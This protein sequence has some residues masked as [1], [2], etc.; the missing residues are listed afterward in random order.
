MSNNNFDVIVVGLGAMGSAAV[1]QL[2]KKH[3][4]VLGIDQ[5]APPHANG[6]SHGET[7]VTRQAIC[8]GDEFVPL[9]LR[10]HEI[11]RDL[12][13]QTGVDLM[14]LCGGLMMTDEINVTNHTSLY[15]EKTIAS[16]KKF[17]IRHELLRA[18][19][20]RKKFPQFRLKGSEIGY[21]EFNTGFLR[22]ERCISV[23]LALA[24]KLGASL[25]INEKVVDIEPVSTD[26]VIVKTTNGSYVGGKVILAVGPWI[27]SLLDK[28]YRHLFKIYRQVLYWFEYLESVL[29]S[30]QR[31]PI[32]M[33]ETNSQKGEA[34]YGFPAVNG[35]GGGIKI[36]FEQFDVETDVDT[37]PR[38]ITAGEKSQMYQQYVFPNFHGITQNVMKTVTCMYTATPDLKFIIDNHPKFPQLLLASPCSGHGF[39]HSAA[40]GEVLAQLAVDGKNTIDIS[41]FT[42]DRFLNN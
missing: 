13:K 9:V 29:Y 8:E 24:Q 38:N 41:K 35:L 19:E 4:R 2:A 32:Y 33:W 18:S 34:L 10:S 14:T 1:Y 15:F 26:K 40:I 36:A 23:Q 6:S 37:T 11:W 30:P 7:R 20:I 27:Q 22:P 12:E 21:C 28:E 25:H 17:N 16:A 3:K 31:C 42:I 5:F 39:K